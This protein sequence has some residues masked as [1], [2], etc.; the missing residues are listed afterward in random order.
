MG[1][2]SDEGTQGLWHPR[3]VPRDLDFESQGFRLG[4]ESPPRRLP[5]SIK[6]PAPARIGFTR[7]PREEDEIVCPNCGGELGGGEGEM[8][9]QVWVVKSCGHVGVFSDSM[10]WIMNLG[11]GGRRWNG[12]F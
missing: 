3:R 2:H 1:D 8:G 11:V 9:R 5:A 6:P 12:R 7:S 4:R 10:G